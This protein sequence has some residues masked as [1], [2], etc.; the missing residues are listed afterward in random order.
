MLSYEVVLADGRIITAD[1]AT[2]TDLLRA[3]KGGSNNFGIVTSFTMP[4][5]PSD[6]IWGGIAASPDTAIP[7][8]VNAMW[9]FT[10][11]QADYQDS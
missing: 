2:N 4:T 10:E 6:R 5:M 7:E 3:L 11:E 9:H 1:R 8:V